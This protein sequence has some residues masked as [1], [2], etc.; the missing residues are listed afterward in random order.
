MPARILITR[1]SNYPRLYIGLAS[2]GGHPKLE[3]LPLLQQVFSEKMKKSRFKGGYV[4]VGKGINN[5]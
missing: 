5:R 1:S 2:N 4:R 3:L